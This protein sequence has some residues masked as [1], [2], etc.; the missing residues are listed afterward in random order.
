MAILT[1]PSF[2]IFIF[3]VLV[4]CILG[5]IF[6]QWIWGTPSDKKASPWSL[7]DAIKLGFGF[8]MGMFL[9]IV[10]SFLVLLF[11]VSFFVGHTLGIPAPASS[12]GNFG[13]L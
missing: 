3:V 1:Q 13:G 2:L 9:W 11:I 4:L 6:Y 12:P 7:G 8:G 5:L 10:F